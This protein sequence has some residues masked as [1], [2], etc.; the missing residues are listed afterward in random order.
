MTKMILMMKITQLEG[1]GEPYRFKELPV[2]L[3]AV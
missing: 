1:I 3:L 2:N